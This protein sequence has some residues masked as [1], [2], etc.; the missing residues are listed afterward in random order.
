MGK[1]NIS[2]APNV[3]IS[4]EPVP[5]QFYL[6]LAFM[7][8]VTC[9]IVV[10]NSLVLI[11]LWKF[12]LFRKRRH[13]F[14]MNV[15]AADL[16]SGLLSSPIVLIT[17]LKR[18]WR[19]RFFLC[20]GR[21]TIG[22][23]WASVTNLLL[24]AATIERYIAIHHPFAH[25][26]TCT[27][28]VLAVSCVIIWLYSS[29]LGA[30]MSLGWNN[31]SPDEI[32]FISLVFPFP[33][34]ILNLS[35]AFA[36]M[37]VYVVLYARIFS[38]ARKQARR[39]AENNVATL[40]CGSA[41]TNGIKAAKVTALVVLVY[42]V[43]YI[44]YSFTFLLGGYDIFYRARPVE[45]V[46]SEYSTS[47]LVTAVLLFLNAGNNPIIYHGIMPSFR[48]AVKTLLGCNR[49]GN[50]RIFSINILDR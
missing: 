40:N 3:T 30:S 37:V 45:E 21:L 42:M 1:E 13:V 2:E 19:S 47:L 49:L 9:V 11:V 20:V 22:Y 14:L 48:A 10:G 8:P 16:V 50:N 24:L 46:Y 27:P 29:T 15:A 25:E 32:C 6:F 18:D 39:I 23:T 5:L 38:T 41:S 7:L 26:K 35:Q 44:P 33:L 12:P 43:C 34:G 17:E 4:N 36:G 31:W 28:R